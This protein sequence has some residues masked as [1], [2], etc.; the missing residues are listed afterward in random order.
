MAGCYDM[1]KRPQEAIKC[2]RRATSLDDRE[3]IALHKLAKLF[4][5]LG[6]RDQVEWRSGCSGR[7]V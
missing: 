2:Y 1:L 7:V 5:E 4:D 6:D 3:G